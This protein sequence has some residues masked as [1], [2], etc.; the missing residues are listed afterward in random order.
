MRT[1]TLARWQHLAAAVNPVESDELAA[2]RA[3]QDRTDY[4][5]GNRPLIVLTRGIPDETGPNTA[6]S[7]AQHTQD[8]SKTGHVVDTGPADHCGAERSSYPAR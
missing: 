2:L 3:E 6:T 4:P 7:E 1:W 5:L 8:Q